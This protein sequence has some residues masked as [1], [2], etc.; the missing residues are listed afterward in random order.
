MLEFIR[1]EGEEN[2]LYSEI[3]NKYIYYIDYYF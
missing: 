2:Y 3:N 1:I